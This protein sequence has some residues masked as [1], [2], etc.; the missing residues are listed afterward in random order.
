MGHRKQ[1]TAA[2][3]VDPEVIA[4]VIQAWE[5]SAGERDPI[6]K[7][8]VAPAARAIVAAAAPQTPQ[9][10]MKHLQFVCA[11]LA[12]AHQTIGSL[13]GTAINPRNV[14]VFVFKAS[15]DFSRGWKGAARWAL[16][17]VG[18]AVN[19]SGWPE[20]S[21]HLS[22][23][24]HS[25]PYSADQEELFLTEAD[26]PRRSTRGSR[27]F[28]VVG[29]CGAGML[30]HEIAV[31][32]ASDVSETAGG[33]LV[34]QVRGPNARLVPIRERYSEAAREALRIVEERPTSVRGVVSP[35]ESAREALRIVEE[36]PEG[37]HRRFL[38]AT[39]PSAPGSVANTLT[40]GCDATEG[41]FSLRRGR[42]TWLAAHLRAGTP[43][44]V[45]KTLA[46][47]VGELTLTRLVDTLE[48]LTPEEAVAEGLRA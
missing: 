40:A 38:T 12:W 33:R 36:R 32:E 14:D 7:N 6:I 10:A 43:L 9:T 28:L 1:Q 15:E 24:T 37:L 17:E 8:T 2:E 31:S 4:Q 46:G 26:L 25:A 39:S 44:H 22:R 47:P 5:P 35:P 42:A 48:P 41:H 21:P 16:S 13:D 27:L 11:F 20:K 45:I 23:P 3:P 29:A 18:R 30:G 34:M 19:P